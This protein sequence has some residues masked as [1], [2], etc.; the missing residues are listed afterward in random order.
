MEQSSLVSVIMPVYN[1]EQYLQ[2]A[3]E[4][5]LNQSYTNLELILVDDGSTDRSSEI[6]D[7]LQ[8]KD[9]RVRVIHKENGG[10]GS[11]R[12]A[13]LG[14]AKGKYIAFCDNDDIF[15]P[16]LLLDNVHLAEE[17]NADI[18]RFARKHVIQVDGKVVKELVPRLKK[19]MVLDRD[20]FILNYDNIRNTSSGVWSA[21]YKKEIINKHN[22]QF[23][24]SFM[25][26]GVEDIKFNIDLYEHAQKVIYNPNVYYV[27]I[28]RNN[29]STSTKF[30]INIIE[31]FY[32]VLE[33][34]YTFFIENDLSNKSPGA[35]EAII[36]NCYLHEISSCLCNKNCPYSFKKKI[37]FLK[38]FRNHDVFSIGTSKE[39]YKELRKKN[40][41]SYILFKL[42][43]KSRFKTIYFIEY[44]WR[45]LVLKNI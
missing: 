4:S 17:N 5:I 3:V 22:I 45:K 25:R 29:H 8:K 41:K 40:W 18:V 21:I 1:S 6:C 31:S 15:L 23:D 7:M 28:H 33:K 42:L 16:D 34:E 27:W 2:K 13:A 11:A 30:N 38:E 43:I 10:I 20:Q 12:N 32:R 9:N 19:K 24:S 26:F 44:T 35:I 14:V 37:R 39:A 36:V